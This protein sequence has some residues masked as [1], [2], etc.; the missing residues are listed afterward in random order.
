MKKTAS[1]IREEILKM[2]PLAI[3]YYADNLSDWVIGA[4]S[5]K[6]KLPNE[7]TYSLTPEGELPGTEVPQLKKLILDGEQISFIIG[8]S[9]PEIC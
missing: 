4:K 8:A 2:N 5:G 9:K 3:L 6:L 1:E 7:W